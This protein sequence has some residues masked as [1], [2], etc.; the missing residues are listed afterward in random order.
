[1]MQE[2]SVNDLLHE[3]LVLMDVVAG[4]VEELM[5]QICG[6][7]QKKGYVKDSY[8]AAVLERE[9]SYPTGLPTEV[10]KVALPH[11][12]DQSHVLKSGIFIAKLPKPVSFKEMGEGI[13]DVPVEMVFM[14]TVNGTKEQLTVLQNIVGMFTKPEALAAL[15]NTNTAADIIAAIKTHLDT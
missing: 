1:M 10:M 6:Y 12:T 15:K 14:L 13:N 5:E 9:N 7:A 11:T 3:D 2:F 8:L 4:S